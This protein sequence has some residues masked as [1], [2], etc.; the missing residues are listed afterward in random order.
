MVLLAADLGGHSPGCRHAPLHHPFFPDSAIGPKRVRDV[1][2]PS[3]VHQVCRLRHRTHSIRQ[4]IFPT[5][6]QR[7]RLRR[8]SQGRPTLD[9]AQRLNLTF[10]RSKASPYSSYLGMQEATDKLG[11]WDPSLLNTTTTPLPRIRV[12]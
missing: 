8:R 2:V 3:Y 6:L 10:C 5:Y 12:R 7:R 4:Q 9:Y 1:L 11:L